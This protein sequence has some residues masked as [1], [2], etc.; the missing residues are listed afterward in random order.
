[1]YRCR[2]VLRPAFI[3]QLAVAYV[4]NGCWF[5]VPGWIPVNKDPEAVN[6]ARKQAGLEPV[7]N[8][9]LRLKRRVYRP[10]VEGL[11]GGTA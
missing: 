1:M 11:S 7:P 2:A 9:C 6:R 8:T 10:F 3:Q 5:Y 4:A